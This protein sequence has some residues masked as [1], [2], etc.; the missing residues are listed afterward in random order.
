M[1]YFPV[2]DSFHSHP[3]Q[4]AAS[5]AAIGL[6]TVAGSWSNEHLTDGFVPDH[7]LPSL[8]RGQVELA[9][10]LVGAGLWK[11]SRGGYQFH[12]WHA[13]ADGSPRNQ[14][15]DEAIARRSKMASGGAL[16]N[17]R[18]WHV[19]K[20]RIDPK[21]GFC[22]AK[23]DRPPTRPANRPPDQVPESGSDSGANPPSPS[24]SPSPEGTGTKD[25]DGTT[26]Q[27]SSRR[28][29]RANG[30]D[31]DQTIDN[32][33]IELL[34]EHTGQTVPPEWAARVRQQI[35]T[36]RTVRASRVAYVTRAITERPA[37]F[38]P[39]DT[40]QQPPPRGRQTPAWCGYCDMR[41]RLMELPGGTMARCQQCH[42]LARSPYNHA[43]ADGEA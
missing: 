29:A 6:W 31:D 36:G 38:L 39:P 14:T 15:R 30:P 3:K 8:S 16:G 17:H 26:S 5:L 40:G 20:G 13:D 27:S 33:I 1:P 32:A 18:R 43:A 25:W 2:D 24:P 12:Q 19:D 4:M 42:P 10:E 9:K 21:C 37:D 7:V 22:Q 23:Q 41:T 11:R 28:N 34:Q 35:L